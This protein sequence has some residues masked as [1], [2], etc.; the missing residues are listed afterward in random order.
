M[1]CPNPCLTSK[2]FFQKRE[3]MLALRKHNK[4]EILQDLY[5]ELMTWDIE[6]LKAIQKRVMHV[7]SKSHFKAHTT[8]ISGSNVFKI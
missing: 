7:I 1:L 3:H 8:Y 2:F 6:K 5:Y 4:T